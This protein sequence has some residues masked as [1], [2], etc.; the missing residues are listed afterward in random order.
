MNSKNY[1]FSGV[2]LFT[3]FFASPM[4]SQVTLIPLFQN[5]EYLVL[6]NIFAVN[7]V[8]STNSSIDGFLEINIEDRNTGDLVSLC[9]HGG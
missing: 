6:D 4:Y 2:I 8:N 1:L 3:L 9:D 5:S 7:I